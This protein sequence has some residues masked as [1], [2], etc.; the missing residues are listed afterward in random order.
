MLRWLPRANIYF[1]TANHHSEDGKLYMNFH[2]MA[3][4]TQIPKKIPLKHKELIG[5][6]L[7]FCCYT[8][9]S[10]RQWNIHRL[11]MIL[12]DFPMKPFI[13]TGFSIEIAMKLMKPF[14]SSL[15]AGQKKKRKPVTGLVARWWA[16]QYQF[17][18]EAAGWVA[19]QSKHP[20]WN[21][22]EFKVNKAGMLYQSESSDDCW[23]STYSGGTSPIPEN[24]AELRSRGRWISS[25]SW[26]CWSLQDHYSILKGWEETSD[27]TFNFSRKQVQISTSHVAR[28][29]N[30]G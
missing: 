19:F 16:P 5:W 8:L 4:C 29:Q 14:G 20:M 17:P 24:L 1:H 2:E 10:S 7:H 26:N 27:M 9:R 6:V 23:M 11:E 12:G 28:L 30:S 18:P 3:G 22:E 21:L 15:F 25:P 13:C